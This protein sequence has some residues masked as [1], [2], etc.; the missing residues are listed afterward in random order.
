MNPLPTPNQD[1]PES[2]VT[3][4]LAALIRLRFQAISSGFQG[5]KKVH[6]ALI[7]GFA[8]PFRGRGMEFEEVRAY[9]PGDDIRNMDWRVTARTGKPHTKLFR[10]ERERP[11]YFLVDLNPSMAFGT[12][13]A[14]KSVVAARIAALLAWSV[15]RKGDRVGGLIFTDQG[16]WE[17]RPASGKRGVLPLLGKICQHL[18]KPGAFLDTPLSLVQPLA[19]LQR[20]T[21]PGSLIFIISD[22]LALDTEALH[23]MSDLARHNDVV[24]IQLH[25]PLEA[26]LPPS[27]RFA[28]GD[29]ERVLNLDVGDARVREGHR[30]RFQTHGEHLAAACGKRN[31]FFLSLATDA[32]LPEALF[33]ELRPLTGRRS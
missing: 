22:F 15:A 32:P 23:R 16:H 2:G 4:S 31:V 11:V 17:S 24:A 28:F 14:F 8:S 7:G 5:R 29:G 10:Q 6:S 1:S 30:R 3:V 9:Q 27:G 25:D 33:R 12:R 21:R 18:P 13:V 19:R 20:V 26:E